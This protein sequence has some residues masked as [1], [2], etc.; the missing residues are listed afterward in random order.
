M[1]FSLVT[2]LFSINFLLINWIIGYK[3]YISSRQ[4]TILTIYIVIL[5]FINYFTVHDVVLF[6]PLA[7]IESLFI[8]K[9]TKSW[10]LTALYSLLKNTIMLISWLFTWDTIQIALLENVISYEQYLYL[11][12]L[13]IVLQQ[14][15]LIIVALIVKKVSAKYLIFDSIAQLPKKYITLSVSSFI[16]FNSLNSL[17]QISINSYGVIPFLQL[18]IVLVALTSIYFYVIYIIS[19]FY[20]QQIQIYLL[21]KKTSQE[22]H[23]IDLANEFRH[24]YRNIL[25]SLNTYLEQKQFEQASTYLASIINY[26]KHFTD[27]SYHT[28]LSTINIPAVQGLLLN[29]FE[30]SSILKIPFHFFTNQSIS[31]FDLPINLIDF[32]RCLSILLDNAVEASSEIENP[33]IQLTIIREKES[34]FIEVKNKL[35]APV[36][37]EHIFKNNFTTKKGHQGKGLLIFIKLLKQYQKTTYS[38]STENN[39]FIASFTLTIRQ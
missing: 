2:I 6:I 37:I 24:D 21:S 38:F 9:Y 29:F 25:L 39:F 5:L 12:P 15:L 17:R 27:V 33:L 23:N 32:I 30:K 26:S 35:D 31:Y 18:T 8:L 19:R 13:A 1:P 4:T 34:L 10:A 16:L 36:A 7:F 22:L 3:K 11:E 14:V 28:Q 20:Q